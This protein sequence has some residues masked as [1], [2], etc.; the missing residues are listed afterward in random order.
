MG[1]C[2][3]S[4]RMKAEQIGEHLRKAWHLEEGQDA[5]IYSRMPGKNSTQDYIK[6][7]NEMK[8]QY[9]VP[10]GVKIAGTDYIEYELAVIAQTNADYIVVDGSE[11][12]TA[13]ANPTLQDNVGLLTFHTLVRTIDW[14]V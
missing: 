14:L 9:D 3:T 12:G 6:M 5:T 13:A 2:R 8:A 1:G 10:V 4:T 7:I 11:G